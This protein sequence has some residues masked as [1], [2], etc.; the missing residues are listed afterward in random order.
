VKF[1]L[2]LAIVCAFAQAE[3]WQKP[4]ELVRALGLK[5]SDSVAVIEPSE[6]LAPFIAN[7]VRALENIDT[8]REHSVDV[9]V[10]YNVLH[11]IDRRPEYYAR[12]RHA[13]Q[14]GGRVVNIDFSA[15]P[16]SLPPIKS[17][18]PEAQALEEFKTAGFRIVQTTNLLP[19]QYFQAFE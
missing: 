4:D 14:F 3:D 19:Y 8:A 2:G 10:L 18:L 5:K 1:L 13:L 11:K 12:L 6:F 17:K 16:P 15:D 7:R 9:I